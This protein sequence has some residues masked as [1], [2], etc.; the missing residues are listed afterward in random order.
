VK[1]FN[2]PNR[3]VLTRGAEPGQTIQLA[4]F[5]ANGPLSDPP[6][7][8]IWIRSATLDFYEPAAPAAVDV[9][10]VRRDPAIDEIVPQSLKAETLAEGFLFTE[11]PVWVPDGYLLFS[12]PNANTIYRWSDGDGLSVF[13]TKSGYTGADIGEY[14]QPGSNGLAVDAE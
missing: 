3:V 1:G 13:R 12:D 11:G 6:P 7:N 2:A 8:F 5:A 9:R 10:V 4:V 14:K